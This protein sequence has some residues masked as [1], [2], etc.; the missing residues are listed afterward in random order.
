[1]P[2]LP[3]FVALLGFRDSFSPNVGR[4]RLATR[5]DASLALP[6]GLHQALKLDSTQQGPDRFFGT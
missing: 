6:A 3:D 2:E 5:L 1:M 4:T